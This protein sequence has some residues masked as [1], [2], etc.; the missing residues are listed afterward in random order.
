VLDMCKRCF[1]RRNGSLQAQE[2]V[3]KRVVSVP[4]GGRITL[5]GTD[6]TSCVKMYANTTANVSS[7]VQT[8][9]NPMKDPIRTKQALK[10]GIEA[11]LTNAAI[12]NVS[13]DSEQGQS[14]VIELVNKRQRRYNNFL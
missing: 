12:L 13:I 5:Y 3:L 4:V 2:T 1:L 14:P 11:T 7:Y 10:I 9:L 8:S 6:G